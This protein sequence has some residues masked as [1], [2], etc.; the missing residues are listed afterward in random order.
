MQEPEHTLLR[1]LTLT[2]CAGIHYLAHG[3][4]SRPVQR[5]FYHKLGV[6]TSHYMHHMSGIL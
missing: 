2:S 5:P 1:Y 6:K 3:Q 4:C